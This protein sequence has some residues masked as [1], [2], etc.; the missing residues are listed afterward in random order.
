V[1]ELLPS[2]IRQQMMA[3]RDPHGNVQV[4]KIETERLLIA[5]VGEELKKR[6]SDG[7]YAGKFAALPQFFG[8]EG[9]SCEPS[10]FD[11]NYCYTLGHT[12]GALVELG[13]TGLIAV[14]R[15]LTGNVRD[16]QPAG[17]PVTRMLHIERR[18]GKDVP[19]IKKA[20]VNLEGPAF[21]EY[22]N[23]RQKWAT[24]DHFAN[25]GGLQ[26]FGSLADTVNST[27]ALEHPQPEEPEEKE[28]KSPA[29][30]SSKKAKKDK[31]EDDK[32]DMD[33]DSKPSTPTKKSSRL[34]SRKE[35]KEKEADKDKEKADKDD[36]K[37][38]GRSR[39]SKRSKKGDDDDE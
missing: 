17:I 20:L 5:V 16:W 28:E 25:P 4:S 6:A 22:K 38:A 18:K 35:Q 1:F 29:K 11:A 10:N 13:K 15:N 26:Y 14:A 36:E 12:I 37:P 34:S 33:V 9:R 39:S 32:E 19:V 8:Y 23:L 7:K 3:D 30:K 21:K 27:L 2:D 31:E 24:E